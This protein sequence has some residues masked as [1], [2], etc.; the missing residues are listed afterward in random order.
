[1]VNGFTVRNGLTAG[2]GGA[3][4]CENAS[5][6]RI[7]YCLIENN[8]ANGNGGAIYCGNSSPGFTNNTVF[9]NSAQ[10]AGGGI[11]MANSSPVILNT[12]FWQDTASVAFEIRLDGGSP[13]FT[14]CDIRGGWSGEGNLN[15]D[16]R[17]CDAENGDFGISDI[18]CC[19]TGGYGGTYIG[20][21]ELGCTGDFLPGDANADGKVNGLDVVYLVNYFKDIGPPIPPPIWRADANGNCNINGIDVVYLVNYL[22]RLGPAPLKGNCVGAVSDGQRSGDLESAFGVE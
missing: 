16:P 21:Y 19:L 10:G 18:S 3:I 12:I 9:G 4:L 14:Y 8:R 1:M 5:S 11:Y 17:F 22:K 2:N 6:P 7:T 15:C 20:A 13:S